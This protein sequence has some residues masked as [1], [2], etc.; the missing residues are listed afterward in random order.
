VAFL[1]T[2]RFRLTQT[3]LWRIKVASFPDLSNVASPTKAIIT[4]PIPYMDMGMVMIRE[5]GVPRDGAMGGSIVSV[6]AT[7]GRRCSRSTRPLGAS[8]A[9]HSS[10]LLEV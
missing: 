8:I 6:S 9:Q 10:H 5:K 3:T 4:I 2:G 7:R 1:I